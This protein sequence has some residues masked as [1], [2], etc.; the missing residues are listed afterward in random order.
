VVALLTG[1]WV[2][3]GAAV[4]I[5][6]ALLTSIK[7]WNG[8]ELGPELLSSPAIVLILLTGF[9]LAAAIGGWAAAWVT[10]DHWRRLLVLLS[11]SHVGTWLVALAAG[12]VPFP[13]WFALGLAAA[14]AAGTWVGVTIRARQVHRRSSPSRT[15]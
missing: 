9:G 10:V 2:T 7:R 8:G 11:L 12:A 6:F 5:G 4:P 15:G 3:V 14:A 1:L 13:A